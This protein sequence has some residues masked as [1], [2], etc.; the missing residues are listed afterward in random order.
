MADVIR[1][2]Q[3]LHKK[4]PTVGVAYAI[5]APAGAGVSATG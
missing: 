2:Y 3:A 4:S 5:G 1:V